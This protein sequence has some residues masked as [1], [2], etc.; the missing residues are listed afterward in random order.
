MSKETKENETQNMSKETKIVTYIVEDKTYIL[1]CPHCNLLIQIRENDLGCKIFRH[2]VYKANYSPIPPHAT[3]ELCEKLL[4]D[5]SIYGCAKPFR[6]IQESGS[7]SFLTVEK[8]D[9]I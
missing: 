6:L 1:E 3:K 5:D 7:P 9:Y 4:L 2:A 8:C